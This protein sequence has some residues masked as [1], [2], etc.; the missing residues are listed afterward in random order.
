MTR[1]P[2]IE[3]GLV[4]LIEWAGPRYFPTRSQEFIDPAFKLYARVGYRFPSG[5]PRVMI[6]LATLDVID[7]MMVRKGLMRE[8]FVFTESLA[9]ERDDLDGVYVESVVNPEIVPFLRD[10]GY[11]FVPSSGFEDLGLGDFFWLVDADRPPRTL[12]IAVA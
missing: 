9:H 11:T 5:V 7:P 2:T 12:P 6:T 8:V 1:I 10:R 3:A 4:G